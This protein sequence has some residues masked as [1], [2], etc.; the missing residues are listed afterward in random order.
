MKT[1]QKTKVV[2]LAALL[3][4]GIWNENVLTGWAAGAKEQVLMQLETE[5][6]E[7]ATEDSIVVAT[8]PKGT[9]VICMETESQEWY[10]VTYQEIAGFV[11]A[12]SVGMYGDAAE[13]SGEFEEVHEENTAQLEA[14]EAAGQQEKSQFLWGTVMAVLVALMF[15][16]GIFTVLRGRNKTVSTKKD[17]KT[18]EKQ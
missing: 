16:T 9:A 18:K 1:L 3:F 4:L 7:E 17:N 15:A 2:F 14:A 11:K 8:L 10:Q 6:A 5:A 13:L 12:E